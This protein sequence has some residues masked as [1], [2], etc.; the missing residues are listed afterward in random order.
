MSGYQRVSN[1]EEH[2]GNDDNVELAP[3][4]SS[5]SPAQQPSSSHLHARSEIST[6]FEEITEEELD[7][8]SR[9]LLTQDEQDQAVANANISIPTTASPPPVPQRGSRAARPAALPSSNDGVFANLSAKPVADEFKDDEA[10]PTYE[11]AAQDAT[12]PYWQTT[13]IAPSVGSDDQVLVEGLP[14]GNVFNFVWNMLISTSFQFI[15][16]MLTYMLHTSHAAKNGSRAGLGMTF[17]QYGFYLRNNPTEDDGYVYYDQDIDGDDVPTSPDQPVDPDRM[18]RNE[19]IAYM[20]MVVGWF[21]VIR[22]VSDYVRA[23]RME[24]I[25]QVSPADSAV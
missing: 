7:A 25:I 1:S 9:R 5:P 18:Q 12:P 16:F 21:I 10:P 20:L 8:E 11:A 24:Q 4:Y 13:V 22:S 17:I 14:V 19:L 23:R 2:L 6:T 15:G 3:S